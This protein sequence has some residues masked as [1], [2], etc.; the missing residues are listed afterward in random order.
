[1]KKLVTNATTSFRFFFALIALCLAASPEA[2]AKEQY[3]RAMY[4]LALCDGAPEI[5]P[6]SSETP[7][8]MA[9]PDKNSSRL[10]PIRPAWLKPSCA[11]GYAAYLNSRKF[12]N[13]QKLASFLRTSIRPSSHQMIDFAD[14]ITLDFYPYGDVRTSQEIRTKFSAALVDGVLFFRDLDGSYSVDAAEQLVLTD[15]VRHNVGWLYERETFFTDT[16]YL[17][18]LNSDSF[19]Q[20]GGGFAHVADVVLEDGQEME[21]YFVALQYVKED[22]E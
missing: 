1:M 5:I 10:E 3:K 22:E 15:E 20:A 6:I 16:F 18:I 21:L 14:F 9:S 2:A 4:V 17:G 19:E 13:E 7:I 8:R 12:S 11:L